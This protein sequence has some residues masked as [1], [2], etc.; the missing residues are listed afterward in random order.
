M[1]GCKRYGN[2][3]IQFFCVDS[4]GKYI[5]FQPRPS[6]D[7]R[8]EPSG[9]GPSRRVG[10]LRPPVPP[11]VGGVPRRRGGRRRPGRIPPLGGG[12]RHADGGHRARAH[13]P[14][15]RTGRQLLLKSPAKCKNL[16]DIQGRVANHYS[17]VVNM[18]GPSNWLL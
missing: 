9:F 13:G 17:K 16:Y 15:S 3:D 6:R 2:P 7:I 1:N 10:P 12:A 11:P 14:C 18:S 5:Q 4:T 8:A